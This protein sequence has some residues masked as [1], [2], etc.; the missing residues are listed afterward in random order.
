MH[1]H[2]HNHFFLFRSYAPTTLATTKDPT[3]TSATYQTTTEKAFPWGKES[4]W[5]SSI[6]APLSSCCLKPHGIS[7][8]ICKRVRRSASEN[9]SGQC[10]IEERVTEVDGHADPRADAFRVSK[11]IRSHLRR[12]A[13]FKLRYM[14]AHVYSLK[15]TRLQCCHWDLPV[16]V[17]LEVKCFFLS[18]V[19]KYFKAKL[20]SGCGVN[21]FCLETSSSFV[22]WDK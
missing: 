19:V 6:W 17:S 14:C 9:L 11:L 8:S 12:C 13:L 3:M 1:Q 5:A 20:R 16:V 2:N 18:F 21:S 22:F 4:T 15:P 10:D 7:P